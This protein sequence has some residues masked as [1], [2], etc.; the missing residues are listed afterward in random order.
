MSLYDYDDLLNWQREFYEKFRSITKAELLYL[1]KAE[2]AHQKIEQII[3][4]H[5]ILRKIE[6]EYYFKKY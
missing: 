3:K 1:D 5:G 6:R 4:E 2:E